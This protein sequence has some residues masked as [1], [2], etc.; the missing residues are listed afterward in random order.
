MMFTVTSAGLALCV[1][2]GIVTGDSLTDEFTCS[3]SIFPI[4]ADANLPIANICPSQECPTD[5]GCVRFE[6]WVDT[7]GRNETLFLCPL[8]ALMS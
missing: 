5:P 4:M 6:I 3:N 1:G 8:P 2:L 7:D